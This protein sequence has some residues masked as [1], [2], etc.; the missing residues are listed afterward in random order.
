MPTC[1]AVILQGVP[2]P[3]FANQAAR[4]ITGTVAD[5]GSDEGV[6]NESIDCYAE[7]CARVQRGGIRAW[8]DARR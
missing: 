4:R 7:L 2:C 3:K 6:K 8:V 5:G 1:Q